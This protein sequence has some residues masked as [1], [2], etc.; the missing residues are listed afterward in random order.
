MKANRRTGHNEAENTKQPIAHEELKRL[1]LE[2]LIIARDYAQKNPAYAR[3]LF[4]LDKT[5]TD[6]LAGMSLEQ[7]MKAVSTGVFCFNIRF[8]SEFATQ[9]A[10]FDIDDIDILLNAIGSSDV[11]GV[12]DN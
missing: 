11:D 1:S 8:S 3:L 4:G 10:S 12:Y 7:V 6:V 5:I 2:V 9:L